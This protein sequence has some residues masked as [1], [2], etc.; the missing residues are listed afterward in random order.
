[1]RPF[2][3]IH[4]MDTDGGEAVIRLPI[5]LPRLITVITQPNHCSFRQISLAIR[6]RETLWLYP[7]VETTA[8]T[9]K[10]APSLGVARM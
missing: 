2:P 8:N 3:A 5:M 7:N 1:M 9:T 6:G 4:F 10:V